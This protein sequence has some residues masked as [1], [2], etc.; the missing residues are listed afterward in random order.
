M[1]RHLEVTMRKW[2]AVVPVV[3][4]MVG[5]IGSVSAHENDLLVRFKG[6]I[7]VQPIAN[8]VPPANPDGTFDNVSRNIVRGVNPA[9]PWRIADL[10]AEIDTNGHISV[11]GR[12]LL[13][14]AGNK[15]GQ[16]AGQ[17]VFATLICEDAL[18][19][20]ERSTAFTGVAI[21]PNGDFEI[22]DVLDSVPTACASPVLLIRAASNGTWFAA[23][24]QALDRD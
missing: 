6:G 16:N 10:R 9:G 4:V 1:V 7:G 14:A 8:V 22:D 21:E 3:A 18:P 5:L 24:I 12:G 15:I 2:F 11:K 19:F 17:R 20:T 23:G 13:L